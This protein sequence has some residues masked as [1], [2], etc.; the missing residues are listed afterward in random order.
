MA[1]VTGHRTHDDDTP[2]PLGDLLRPLVRPALA[3]A[4]LTALLALWLRAEPVEITRALQIGL[5]ALPAVF[6]GAVIWY[7]HQTGE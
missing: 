1:Q 5:G 2:A 3:A 6:F 7:V 4:A